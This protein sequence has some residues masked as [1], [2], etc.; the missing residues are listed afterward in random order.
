MTEIAPGVHAVV[1]RR[2][3]RSAAFLLEIDNGLILIDTLFDPNARFILDALKR[4]G[5]TAADLTTTLLTHAHPAHLAGLAALKEMSGA[6]VCSHESEAPIIAGVAPFQRPSFRPMRPLSVYWRIYHLHLATLLR[7]GKQPPCPVDRFLRD[8]DRV[9]P[10]EVLHT[11]GHAPGHLA[12]W[13]PERR[14]LFAGDAVV[15]YPRF[16]TGWPA[17]TLDPERHRASLKRMATLDAEVLAVGHGRPVLSNGAARLRS[18][19]AGR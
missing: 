14:V 17:F 8:G 10:L 12:F 6:T 19:L 5:R 9:G 11:P 15:T 16:D 18:L 1:S 2:V 3:G 13:W 7:L 4:I